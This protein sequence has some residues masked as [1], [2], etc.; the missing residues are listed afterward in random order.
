MDSCRH[1]TSPNFGEEFK[2]H[3][4]IGSGVR[5][6]SHCLVHQDN[7][8]L[9]LQLTSTPTAE[10]VQDFY[11]RAKPQMNQ[12]DRLKMTLKESSKNCVPTST[13]GNAAPRPRSSRA[14]L[15]HWDIVDMRPPFIL[16][17]ILFG[18][19]IFCIYSYF[20]LFHHRDSPP[21]ILLPLLVTLLYPPIL[22]LAVRNRPAEA[23]YVFELLLAFDLYQLATSAFVLVAIL[24]EANHLGM[25]AAFRPCLAPDPSS[26]WL[27][28]PLA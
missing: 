19:S 10:F 5:H 20:V 4:A 25:L 18:V 7:A 21:S 12:L 8:T 11:T 6:G 14:E 24:A 1:I 16:Q 23:R 9:L 3:Q 27:Q 13:P 2:D 26:S 17:R 28:A 15:G 22:L